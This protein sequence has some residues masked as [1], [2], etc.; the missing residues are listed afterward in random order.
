MMPKRH[1][2]FVGV[3]L[4]VMTNFYACGF[5]SLSG[6]SIENEETIRIDYFPNKSRLVSPILSP[7]FTEKLQQKFVNE[8][9]LELVEQN[10]DLIIDGSI[11][12][13]SVNPAASGGGDQAQLNRLTIEVLV[14]FKNTLKDE[15]WTQKFRRYEDFEQN[16]TLTDVE[17]VLIDIIAQ[18]LVDDI[19]NKALVNW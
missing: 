3:I 5:Y 13:Y 9:P 14:N 11:T 18:Q 4:F 2:F 15:E 7:V 8:S 16:E 19:F 1:L 17:E 12:G 6:I 10:A